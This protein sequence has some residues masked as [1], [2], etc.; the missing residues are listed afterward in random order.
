MSFNNANNKKW[1]DGRMVLSN[2]ITEI[3]QKTSKA[4]GAVPI[5]SQIVP[6][7]IKSCFICGGSN[8]TF[9]DYDAKT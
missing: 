3:I 5:P 2:H 9:E 1:K 4:C 7:V 8:L 6:T